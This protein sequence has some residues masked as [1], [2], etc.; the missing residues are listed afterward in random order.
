MQV[1]IVHCHPEPC[2]FN[3]A[4]TEVAKNKFEALGNT[5]E[6]SDLH[7]QK[8]DPVESARHYKNR[9]DTK[10]FAPLSEQ[11]HAYR[12][13]TIPDDVKLEIERL[14][15]CDLVVFQFPIWWHSVPAILKGWQDRVFLSGGLYTSQM[16]YNQGYFRGKRAMSV[17]TSSAVDLLV[18]STSSVA[19][20]LS[21]T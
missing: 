14:E 17:A 5:V 15:R 9:V 18:L 10:T 16:R 3:A 21:V 7:L 19:A 8:F 1:L 11:R 20:V 13:N 12:S 2:S 4:L 6:V